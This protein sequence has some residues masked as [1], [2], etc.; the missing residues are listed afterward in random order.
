MKLTIELVPQTAW[1]SNVRSNV[2]KAEW[3]VLRKACYKKAGY[4]CEVCSGKGPKHP[5]ECH[6]IWEYDDKKHTQT[7]IGLIAL[8]PNCHKCKHMGY[9]RISGN[10]DIALKHLAKVN[11]ITLKEAEKYVDESFEIWDK[12]SQ[13][14]WKLDIT[15]LENKEDE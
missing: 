4:K 15:I 10:Y 11:E 3:D 7:L 14:D 9:A 1:Y 8:C 6:E 13:N 2:T 5:V 12:R